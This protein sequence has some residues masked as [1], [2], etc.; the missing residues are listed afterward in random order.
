MALE[1]EALIAL[2]RHVEAL[3]ALPCD[4]AHE[5]I[6]AGPDGDPM[7]SARSPSGFARTGICP[8][9]GRATNL[10]CSHTM[11]RYVLR[12][13][14]RQVP[15][16]DDEAVA[17]ALHELEQAISLLDHRR[18]DAESRRASARLAKA[19]GAPAEREIAALVAEHRAA[20][21]RADE[22]RD[23]VLRRIDDALGGTSADTR[24]TKMRST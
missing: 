12:D 11:A 14:I 20:V 18:Y 5:I 17:A 16:D 1:R 3:R 8:E 19:D 13:A 24:G 22:L 10:A 2:R 7:R 15:G 6:P 9:A 23:D 21:T 4:M